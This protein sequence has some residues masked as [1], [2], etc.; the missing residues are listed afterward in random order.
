MMPVLLR[1]ANNMAFKNYGRLI[2]ISAD[3]QPFK[4]ESPCW[5][6]ST[7]DVEE[8]FVAAFLANQ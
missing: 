2:G 1:S 8:N 6:P 3:F 5:S 4:R 7:R